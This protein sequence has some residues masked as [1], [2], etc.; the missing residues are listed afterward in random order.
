MCSQ[1]NVTDEDLIRFTQREIEASQ[2]T[3]ALSTFVW[4]WPDDLPAKL[5]T[6][7]QLGVVRAF[8][9]FWDPFEKLEAVAKFLS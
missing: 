1:N 4:E 6:W 2:R 7:E 8:L 3:I 9:T 5:A